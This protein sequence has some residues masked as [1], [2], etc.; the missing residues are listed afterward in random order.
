M[1]DLQ[2]VAC[3]GNLASGE[4]GGMVMMLFFS[5]LPMEGGVLVLGLEEGGF[6][7]GDGNGFS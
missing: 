3:E 4:V 2:L 6:V 5:E 1:N 7:I